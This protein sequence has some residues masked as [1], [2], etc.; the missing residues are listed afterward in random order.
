MLLVGLTGGIAS[1]KSTVGRSLKDKGFTIVDADD[2]ARLVV[3]PGWPALEKIRKAFGDTVILP[4]GELNREALGAIIFNDSSKRSQLNSIVHP[5]IYKEV[6][7]Q[8]LRCFWRREHIVFL[9]MPLL[10][11]TGKVLPYITC[12]VVVS[13]TSDQQLSRLMERNN[14][15]EA[16]ARARISSQ[17]SLEEKCR[18]ANFV[19]DNSE[20]EEERESQIVKLIDTLYTQFHPR[21][22]FIYAD[23]CVF[24]FGVLVGSIIWKG[25]TLL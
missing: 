5:E 25:F 18:R 23:I 24:L 2:I 8:V 22:R 16:D 3:Q 7:R 15:T 6:F 19:I 12:V 14:L 13:C 9:D 20:G 21:R 10:Y 11:E 17:M 1:G 4:S